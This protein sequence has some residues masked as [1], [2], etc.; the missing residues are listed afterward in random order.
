V[1]KSDENDGII[2]RAIKN[3]WYFWRY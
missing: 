1:F 2:P 3:L